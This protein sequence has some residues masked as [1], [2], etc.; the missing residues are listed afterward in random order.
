MSSN[1]PI[2]QFTKALKWLAYLIGATLILLTCFIAS[3]RY[4]KLEDSKAQVEQL[5]VMKAVRLKRL[6]EKGDILA[7]NSLRTAI[8]VE[9]LISASEKYN[10][11]H[12]WVQGYLNVEFEGDA[13][14]W[15]ES[16]YRA[17]EYRCGFGVQFT[18]LL[19]ETKPV[20]DYSKRY[21]VIRG[22]FRTGQGVF[23]GVITQ[24]DSLNTI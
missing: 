2:D 8:T 12:V 14:Y 18:N 3:F 9:A 10:N 4:I 17:N 24:I 20:A 19:L 11:Q 13:I 23:P 6:R 21:V 5:K 16:D 15:R 7:R 1:L 22:L